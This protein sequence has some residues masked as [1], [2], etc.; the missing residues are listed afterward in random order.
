MR[1]YLEHFTSRIV[2]FENLKT[3]LKRNKFMR[4]FW[5]IKVEV[6][7]KFKY[8]DLTFFQ[9]K[10]DIDDLDFETGLTNCEMALELTIRLDQ[11]LLIL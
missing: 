10:G 6:D 5:Q 1:F 9:L 4:S 7:G 8:F 3:N 11:T 2:L